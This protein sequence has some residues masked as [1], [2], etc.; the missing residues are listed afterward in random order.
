MV[1]PETTDISAARRCKADARDGL[2]EKY[3]NG[4]CIGISEERDEMTLQGFTVEL[5]RADASID[6]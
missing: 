2:A 4:V 3:A 6:A 5:D 1:P